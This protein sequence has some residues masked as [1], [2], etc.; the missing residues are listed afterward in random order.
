MLNVGFIG[1]WSHGLVLGVDVVRRCCPSGSCTKALQ[2]GLAQKPDRQGGGG[3]LNLDQGTL[4]DV[5]C[6]GDGWVY[7]TIGESAGRGVLFP[8]GHNLLEVDGS[9]SVFFQIGV[10]N[11][12]CG[13]LLHFQLVCYLEGKDWGQTSFLRMAVPPTKNSDCRQPDAQRDSV[14]SAVLPLWSSTWIGSTPLS[15]V[16]FCS[17]GLVFGSR[18]DG[19]SYCCAIIRCSCWGLVEWG[20]FTGFDAQ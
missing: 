2:A 10:C 19:G 13:F 6:W 18:L 7:C 11:S 16:P 8:A 4:E 15:A 1:W 9:W 20:S 12:V 17:G 14:W 5:K 3:E